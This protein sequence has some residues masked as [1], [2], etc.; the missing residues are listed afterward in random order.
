M[1]SSEFYAHRYSEG[2]QRDPFDRGLTRGLRA[3]VWS[4]AQE[5]LRIEPCHRNMAPSKPRKWSGGHA[6][7]S[8]PGR[9]ALR[10]RCGLGGFEGRRHASV[11]A[12]LVSPRA[13]R[14]HSLL[15]RQ[16][17]HRRAQGLPRK[18]VTQTK[19]LVEVMRPLFAQ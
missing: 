19:Q 13:K 11:E 4:A 8:I 7:S 16:T 5:R 10:L 6:Q 14:G 1:R 3:L 17:F 15:T 12:V 9:T 18:H 2:E